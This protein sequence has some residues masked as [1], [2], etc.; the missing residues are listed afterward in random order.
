MWPPPV[1]PALCCCS[2]ELD[3]PFPSPISLATALAYFADLLSSPRKDALL[4]LASC[5]TDEA[6]AARL[7]LLASP[8][9]KAEYTSYIAKP[10]RSLL[11][12]GLWLA[13]SS[14]GPHHGGLA[15]AAVAETPAGST[16]SMGTSMCSDLHVP[17]LV[18]LVRHCHDLHLFVLLPCYCRSCRTSPRPS[19]PWVCS[20]A[21]SRPAWPRVSTPSAAA[22]RS[23][24]AACT[25]PAPSSGR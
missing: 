1:P 7:K 25:S 3:P 16:G 14:L 8:Q 6:Q 23:T 21:P 19:P 10:H 11:E 5:A 13:F 2:G 12:V 9:G 18:R 24:H 15:A 22:A 4:G 17:F 20:L